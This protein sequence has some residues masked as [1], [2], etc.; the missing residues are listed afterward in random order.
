M[1]EN[2]DDDTDRNRTPQVPEGEQDADSAGEAGDC[3]GDCGGSSRRTVMRSMAGGVASLGTLAAADAIAT[4]DGATDQESPP[5]EVIE[6]IF[7]EHYR[8]MTDAEKEELFERLE[9]DYAEHGMDV[10][11]K[12]TEAQDGV[13]FGYALNIQKCIGCRQ[14]V[15]ACI[16]ENNQARYDSDVD[17]SFELDW[18]RVLELPS[19]EYDA[20][21]PKW[22][23]YGTE[24]GDVTAGI[25]YDESDH[26]YDPEEVPQEG[27]T[28]LP[29]QCQQCEDPPCVKVCPVEATWKEE[30]GIVTVDYQRCIGCKYCV[31]ACPYYARRINLGHPHLPEDEVNPDTHY[32]GNRPRPHETV[33]KCTYC[34][35]RSREGEYPACVET[36]PVGARKFGNL[37][38]PESEVRQVIENK[39]V[40]RLKQD[41]GTEPKFFYYMD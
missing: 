18:I 33:E 31:V 39:K 23:N 9:E 38:D 30:D 19:F 3:D 37:L 12:G 6:D 36:C 10:N 13:L 24:W 8:E 34:I 26:F 1:R 5:E 21:G 40:F 22:G 25:S 17:H 32:L 28:Y 35:Q 7:G 41:L 29:V 11:I 27:K 14:C 15:N 4:V 20:E 16:E 2:M